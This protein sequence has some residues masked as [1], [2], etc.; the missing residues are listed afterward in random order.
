[1]QTRKA[2]QNSFANKVRAAVKQI[3]P[4]QVRTYKEI[5]TI[6]GNENASRAVARIMSQNFDTEIPCHRVIRSD[7]TLAGYN[8]GGTDAKLSLLKSEGWLPK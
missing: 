4:G 1:M 3:P 5:A 7:G 2:D 6:A 8:R